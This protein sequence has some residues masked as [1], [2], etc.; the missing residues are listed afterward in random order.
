MDSRP[1]WFAAILLISQPI[2]AAAPLP[3]PSERFGTLLHQDDFRE[4]LDQW[5][6]EIERPGRI[7]AQMGVMEIDVP[8]G[9]TLWFKPRLSGPVAIEFQ[10]TAIKARGR[11]D[12]GADLNVFWMANNGDGAV[13]VF[14]H[15]RTGRTSDY[16][17]LHGYF[18]SLGGDNNT[19]SR[20][21][22]YAG[23]RPR[24]LLEPEHELSTQDALLPANRSVTVTLVASGGRIEYWRNTQR[25]FELSDQQPWRQGW[26][27][28]RTM[29][30][31]LKI[32]RLRIYALE[33]PR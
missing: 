30:S 6:V 24:A 15:K 22:R 3:H 27:A 8:G 21:L 7:A 29:Q 10:A 17:T 4:G 9:V 18:A 33:P 25:L 12:R 5:H 11:N 2:G 13:P 31:H 14:A 20:F 1:V 26:F 28:I 19:R 23:E 16:D 32:S